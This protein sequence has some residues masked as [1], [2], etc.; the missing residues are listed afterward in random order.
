MPWNQHEGDIHLFI[1]FASFTLTGPKGGH[2]RQFV[3]TRIIKMCCCLLKYNFWLN[4]KI[5]VHNNNNF[6]KYNKDYLKLT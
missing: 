5:K 3:H 6:E 1:Y 4:L 2:Y